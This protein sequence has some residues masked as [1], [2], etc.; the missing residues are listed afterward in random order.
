V[1]PVPLRDEGR[2]CVKAVGDS[3]VRL[4][5]YDSFSTNRPIARESPMVKTQLT[6][7]CIDVGLTG[8]Y[9]AG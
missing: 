3:P 5:H 9:T 4:V 2:A 6:G 1:L 7:Y 8:F